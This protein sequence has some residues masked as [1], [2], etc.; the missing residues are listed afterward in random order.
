MLGR[1]DGFHWSKRVLGVAIIGAGRVGTIRAATIRRSDRAFLAAV[2]DT[3]KARAKKLAEGTSAVVSQEWSSILARSDVQAVVVSTPT[4]FHVDVVIPALEAGKHVLCEKPLGRT[5][6]EAQKMCETSHNSRRLLKTG[7]NY[8]H[9]AHVLQARRLL[10]DNAL[11]SLYFLRCRYGHGGRPGYEKEW[12]TDAEL[13]G[14]G[15]LLEQG[16]HIFDLVRY[17]LG[18]PSRLAAQARR[19]FWNF[20]SVEDNGFCL[21]ETERGQT[22][23]IHI[24]WTQWVNIFELE[25]FGADGFVRLEG[26]DSHYG[27]QRLVW[28]KRQPDHSRPEHVILDFPVPDNSWDLEWQEFCSAIEQQRE[29][30]GSAVDGLRA[31]QLIEAAYQS[32]SR[33]AWIEV[34]ALELQQQEAPR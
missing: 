26:R 23:Q 32:V 29:P 8:R 13:S 21:L 7:F 24:S 11:G 12:C 20:P 3:D 10:Q 27:P 1:F 16:I 6:I 31:Q 2:V 34:P 4:K 28:G 19:Y 25:L 33:R 9:M 14:G 18:E 17:L 5:V 22:A 15:V 30:V